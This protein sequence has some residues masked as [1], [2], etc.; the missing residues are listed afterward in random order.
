MSIDSSYRCDAVDCCVW[1]FY[2]LVNISRNKYQASITHKVARVDSTTETGYF[3]RQ[4]V[5]DVFEDILK[6]L[7]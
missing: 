2:V 3:V 6:A 4:H 1:S 5:A 7:S